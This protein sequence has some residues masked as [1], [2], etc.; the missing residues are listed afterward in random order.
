MPEGRETMQLQIFSG[1]LA[2]FLL[3]AFPMHGT[4]DCGNALEAN[5]STFRNAS[6][7]HS[8]AKTFESEP[9]ACTFAVSRRQTFTKN[10]AFKS[11]IPDD[12]NEHDAS[13][14]WNMHSWC[15]HENSIVQN[16]IFRHSSGRFFTDYA[17]PA[18]HLK[19][20]AAN[21]RAG[22]GY[23]AGYRKTAES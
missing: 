22:P 10:N 20:S 7:R 16:T 9:V 18:K 5:L 1:I 4:A 21:V 8:I 15:L 19:N 13:L 6:S 12:G 3:F 17:I 2:V 14:A 11:L 23:A